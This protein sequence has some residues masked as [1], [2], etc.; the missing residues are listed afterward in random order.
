M[1]LQQ[2]KRNNQ[3][4]INLP[5]AVVKALRWEKSIELDLIIKKDRGV[6]LRQKE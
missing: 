1:K 5:M 3:Y 4:Y 2:N 6:L